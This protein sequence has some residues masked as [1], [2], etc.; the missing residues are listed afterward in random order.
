[1]SGAEWKTLQ[2]AEDWSSCRRELPH[3][4]DAEA[5]LVE[6]LIRGKVERILDLG[7]G[8]GH[9]IAVLREAGFDDVDCF[10]KWLELA[11]VGG[12]KSAD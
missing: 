4:A 12:T 7:C 8:D 11:L 9:M 2:R 1:M 5:M 10:W 3:A 6:H